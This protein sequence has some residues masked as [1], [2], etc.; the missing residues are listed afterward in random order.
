M[1]DLVGW[2][3]NDEPR[4]LTVTARTHDDRARA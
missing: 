2:A 4:Q 1:K 3:S